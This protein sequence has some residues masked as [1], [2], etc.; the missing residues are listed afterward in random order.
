MLVVLVVGCRSLL[1]L[2]GFLEP[3]DVKVF[4]HDQASSLDH[5][6][7]VCP[8][9]QLL[10]VGNPLQ[11]GTRLGL[12]LLVA[13]AGLATT[14]RAI[15]IFPVVFPGSF[16]SHSGSCHH[17]LLNG[18]VFFFPLD[19]G[20]ELGLLLFFKHRH[21]ISGLPILVLALLASYDADET[22]EASHIIGFALLLQ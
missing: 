21:H 18:N 4:D 17:R 16:A 12:G 20:Q 10:E 11:G 2:F 3:L 14:A 1:G 7:G 8:Q 19:L 9:E 22:G 13:V 5:P 15:G 6:F